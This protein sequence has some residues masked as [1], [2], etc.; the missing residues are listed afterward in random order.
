MVGWSGKVAL[1]VSGNGGSV[2]PGGSFRQCCGDFLNA[3][4]YACVR[5]RVRVFMTDRY[6]AMAKMKKHVKVGEVE[7]VHADEGVVAGVMVSDGDVVMHEDG[8]KET[9]DEDGDVKDCR[10]GE[11]EWMMW[12]EECAHGGAGRS[13]L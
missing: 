3:D 2:G 10:L 5:V 7:V 9:D 11:D 12:E 4:V 13:E 8:G 1:I 6:I